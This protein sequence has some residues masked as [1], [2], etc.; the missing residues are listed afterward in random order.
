AIRRH[1]EVLGKQRR[2]YFLVAGGSA[3]AAEVSAIPF[4]QAILLWGDK[5]ALPEALAI[6]LRDRGVVLE[7]A[8][9]EGIG[10]QGKA[11]AHQ[12]LVQRQRVALGGAKADMPL[13]ERL[14]RS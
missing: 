12:L 13:L 8:L 6:V 1:S 14:V 4:A 11:L 7:L 2:A 10:V 9:D 3:R 5:T